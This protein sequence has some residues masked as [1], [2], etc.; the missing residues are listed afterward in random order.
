MQRENTKMCVAWNFFKTLNFRFAPYLCL[1]VAVSCST[2]P[3]KQMP[4]PGTLGGTSATPLAIPSASSPMAEPPGGSGSL[5][6]DTS[7]SLMQDIK[8][9][10]VGDIVTITVSEKAQASKQSTVQTGKSKD[11][12]GDLKFNGLTYA[13]ANL[14]EA[15]ETG[16]TG[17]F[18]NNYKGTGTASRNDTMTTYMTATVVEVLPNGNLVIRGSRWTKVNEETQQIILE[19]MVRP[20]DIN[21]NNQILSQNIADAKIFFVGKGT[22]SSTQKTGWL[23]QL[24]DYISPF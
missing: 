21:R 20:N 2:M 15:A 11:F 5:W 16:Y 13:G 9:W 3:G 24:F 7:H 4:P 12:S 14:L 18:A 8:A 23:G 19:G 17:K 22:V 6:R 10:K 1:L